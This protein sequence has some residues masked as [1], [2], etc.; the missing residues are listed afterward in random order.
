MMKYKPRGM[1]ALVQAFDR[2]PG[3][4][5]MR[6]QHTSQQRHLSATSRT[7]FVPAL[8]SMADKAGFI[9]F[10]D[11]KLVIFYSNDLVETPPEPGASEHG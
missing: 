8:Q 3:Y 6:N 11:S 10:K 7:A 2:D 4:G 1:W 9:V 5:R